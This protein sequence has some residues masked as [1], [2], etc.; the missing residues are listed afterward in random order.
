M[1]RTKRPWVPSSPRCDGFAQAPGRARPVWKVKAGGQITDRQTYS[2]S[3][4][5]VLTRDLQ[6]Q[7]HSFK[8]GRITL[9]AL[10]QRFIV[11]IARR[12]RPRSCTARAGCPGLSGL[13][14][15]SQELTTG[16]HPV[17]NAV[18]IPVPAPRA[19]KPFPCLPGRL[20]F[21]W[22]GRSPQDGV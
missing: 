7:I 12:R 6:G 15:N 5:A 21:R 14:D 11:A 10:W 2:P 1:R 4:M 16:G 22:D 13:R 20:S 8:T 19:Y 18:G 17:E 3:E 9:Q